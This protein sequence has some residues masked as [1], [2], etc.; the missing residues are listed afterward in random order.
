MN[1][2]SFMIGLAFAFGFIL[3]SVFNLFILKWLD[4]KIYRPHPEIKNK[5]L[6]KD[7]EKIINQKDKQLKDLS[8]TIKNLHINPHEKEK[9]NEKLKKDIILEKKP[10]IIYL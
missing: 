3:G 9:E 1:N 4:N 6:L 10:I 8:L 5:N 2:W 7:I